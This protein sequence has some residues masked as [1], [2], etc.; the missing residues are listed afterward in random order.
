MSAEG[1]GYM[2]SLR[3]RLLSDAMKV[4]LEMV[5]VNMDISKKKERANHKKYLTYSTL[6]QRLEGQVE[7]DQ[8]SVAIDL[9]FDRQEISARTIKED[10]KWVRAYAP[11]T[12]LVQGAMTALFIKTPLTNY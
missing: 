10:D 9:L 1:I 7:P 2:E 8:V 11:A 4:L 12:E 6:C 3:Y 5:Y